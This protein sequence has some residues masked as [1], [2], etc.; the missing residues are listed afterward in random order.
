[1]GLKARRIVVG[2][3]VQVLYGVVCQD[4]APIA[5]PCIGVGGIDHT[6]GQMLISDIIIALQE[7]DHNFLIID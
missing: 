7:S 6:L 5:L 2:P 1:M 4:N 3:C